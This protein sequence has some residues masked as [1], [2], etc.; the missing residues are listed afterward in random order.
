[1]YRFLS[2]CMYVNDVYSILYEL[3]SAWYI[4]G[5]SMRK[6][7]K[8]GSCTSKVLPHVLQD[9][10]IAARKFDGTGGFKQIYSNRRRLRGNIPP[11]QT[12]VTFLS[13]NFPRGK[14]CGMVWRERG[15]YAYFKDP[16]SFV[17]SGF[18]FHGDPDG[19]VRIPVFYR[20]IM[21]FC[22]RALQYPSLLNKFQYPWILN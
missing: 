22:S 5:R 6:T 21:E 20:S 4:K 3:F 11:N 10:G 16:Y 14:P 15:E 8:L 1:M 17:M 2:F 9:W 13:A 12:Y 18:D 7:D 19:F